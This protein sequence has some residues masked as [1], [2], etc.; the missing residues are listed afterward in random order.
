MKLDAPQGCGKPARH[1]FR[2]PERGA[3]RRHL[4][5]ASD[6]HIMG[7]IVSNSASDVLHHL[8]LI[9]YEPA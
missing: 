7:S 4:P 8:D 3:A 5:A 6:Q 2:A 1:R 9:S